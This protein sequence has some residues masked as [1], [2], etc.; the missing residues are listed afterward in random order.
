MPGPVRA[1]ASGPSVPANAQGPR[2]VV[3]WGADR[4]DLLSRVLRVRAAGDVPLVAD[5]RLPPERL[6][7]WAR[8]LGAVNLPE[9]AAWAAMTSGSTGTPRVVVRTDRSWSLAFPDLDRILGVV[10]ED[11][12]LLPVHPVSSMTTFSLAHARHSGFAWQVPRRARLRLEDLE[13][14]TLAHTTPFHF[15]EMLDLL[16]QIPAGDRVDR[17]PLRAVLVGGDRMAQALRNRAEGLGIRTLTYYGAAELSLVAVDDGT[18]LRPFP[19]VDLQVRAER[20]ELADSTAGASS[21]AVA[22]DGPEPLGK[23]SS[24]EPDAVEAGSCHGIG[25]L[26]VRTGQQ[27][28]MVLDPAKDRAVASGSG[29][30]R[31]GDWCTVGDRARWRSDDRLELLGR[32]DAAILTGGA[33]VVPGVVERALESLPEVAG[34]LVLGTPHPRLGQLVTAYVQTRTPAPDLTALRHVLEPMLVPSHRPRRWILVEELPR[35]ASGKVRRLDHAQA[36]ALPR[37]STR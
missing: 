11:R 24:E 5:E 19:G 26:W 7:E 17:F 28:L 1:A 22:E 25:T 35:T 31:N 20:G 15:A 12:M 30:V 27:A 23:P 37:R 4:Q 10:P 33:T 18:G 32:Q 13:G 34:A 14:I 29:L 21:P 3:L 2:L 8:T 9:E 36:E 6:E 16:E